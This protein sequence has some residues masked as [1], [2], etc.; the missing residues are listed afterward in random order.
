MHG[1]LAM[2]QVRLN[3]VI[4][5]W[6]HWFC[7]SLGYRKRRLGIRR[8]SQRT[9]LYFPR[10]ALAMQLDRSCGKINT[11]LGVWIK[12]N[13]YLTIADAVS[14][15]HVPWIIIGIWYASCVALLF[16][17]RVLLAR[18]NKRRDV[19]PPDDTYED[20]YVVKISEDGS[21]AEIKVSKV[22]FCSLSLVYVAG[23][24]DQRASRMSFALDCLVNYPLSIRDSAELACQLLDRDALKGR[25][26]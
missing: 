21:P 20:V 1:I 19:E 23:S 25:I 10:T 22:N 17:I 13:R 6:D 16:S 24:C 8:I 5:Y 9:R 2:A 26:V 12:R 15:N 3:F 18:E 4:R 14:S 7:L 11:S